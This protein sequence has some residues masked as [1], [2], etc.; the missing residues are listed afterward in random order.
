MAQAVLHRL[1]VGTAVDQEGRLRVPE[2][3]EVVAFASASASALHPVAVVPG[4][5]L[6]EDSKAVI[7]EPCPAPLV[8]GGGGR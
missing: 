5:Y 4:L 2:L 3:V 6:L 8:E 1:D 7:D